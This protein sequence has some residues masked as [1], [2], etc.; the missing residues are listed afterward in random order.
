MTTTNAQ[1]QKTMTFTN[2]TKETQ[3]IVLDEATGKKVQAIL[4][5]QVSK[6]EKMRQL[7]GIEGLSQ[8]KI[9]ALMGVIPQFVNNVAH[10]AADKAQKDA[11][12]KA[13]TK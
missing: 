2:P 4:G 9:A 8:Y 7:L 12:K 1:N 13:A 11:Q 6:S 10:K 3:K 5:T